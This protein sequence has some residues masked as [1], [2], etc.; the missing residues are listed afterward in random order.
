MP[1][2]TITISKIDYVS[3]N[4]PNWIHT[5]D[6]ARLKIW[7][8]RIDEVRVG[9]TYEIPYYDKEYNGVMERTV[10]SKGVIKEVAGNGS[11]APAAPVEPP[12]ATSPPRG[13]DV[14][15]TT[16]MA[17]VGAA[18]GTRERSIVAQAIIKSVIGVAGS[19][20]DVQKWV[21]CHDAIVAGKRV[22]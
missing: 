2:A 14:P 15:P 20:A 17:V 6:G 18:Q 11:S 21:D 4:A 1:T 5:R 9:S 12:P 7:D 22:D 3:G 13:D 8:D 19:P 10:G 16:P